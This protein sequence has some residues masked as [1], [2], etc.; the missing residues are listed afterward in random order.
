[1]PSI[2]SSVTLI[3]MRYYRTACRVPEPGH[4][5]RCR[6][7]CCGAGAALFGRSREKRGGSS[8]RSSY[9]PMFEEKIEQKC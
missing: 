1:M 2:T 7:Q 8:S 9:D 5:G 3:N 4:F 6:S